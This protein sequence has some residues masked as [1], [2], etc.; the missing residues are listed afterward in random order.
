M[1]RTTTRLTLASVAFAVAVVMA[2][3]LA[4]P[5]RAQTVKDPQL[6]AL[7]DAR[8]Y[9]EAERVAAARITVRPDDMDAYGALTVAVTNDGDGPHREA[10]LKRLE[11]CTAA[12]PNA[13]MCHFGV[14]AVLGV[15]AMSQ[16]MVAGLRS[17]GRI[18]DSFIKALEIDP[19]FY[20]ARSALVQYYLT[21]PGIAGGSVSKAREVAN[22]ASNKQPEHAKLLLGMIA[23]DQKEFAQAE[24][25]AATVRAGS[26]KE[27]A[28]D[29]QAFWPQLGIA[30]LADK[31]VAKARAVFERAV[32]E[33]PQQAIGH[34]GL[35]RT[36]AESGE[37]DAAV[38]A[39]QRALSLEGAAALPVD[40]R[41]GIAWQAKGERDKA[42]AAFT[43][44]IG[45][46]KGSPKNLDDAKKRLAELA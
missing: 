35:G 7:L 44:F 9:A 13:A 5:A 4:L 46:G 29:V 23:L 17:V 3:G 6:A 8:K 31:Q 16:G 12:L 36:L 25:V 26:D 14:G 2:L 38:A 42:R 30:Y 40:Y 10:A 11:A 1:I 28:G 33:A 32:Q 43:R 27:L 21:V 18:R 45:A 34:Y 15:N 19:L 39:Y 41:L 20:A 22:A 24:R 37:F